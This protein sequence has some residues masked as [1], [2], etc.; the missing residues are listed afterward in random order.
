MTILRSHRSKRESSYDRT[1]GNRDWIELAPGET[2]TLARLS[3]AGCINRLYFIIRCLDHMYLRKLV[4]RAYWDGEETPSVEVPFGD[5]FGNTNGKLC[6][7][8]S[9]AL[10]VNPGGYGANVADGFNCFLPMPFGSSA[11]L[12]IQNQGESPILRC[13]YHVDYEE[14]DSLA[15][16]VGR[17]HAQWRREN[18]TVAESQPPGH[19]AGKNVTG[20]KN[21]VVLDAEGRGNFV[22]FVFGVDNSCGDWWG[23]GDDMIF[24]DGESWPP[25]LHGTGTEEIF[26][27]GACPNVPYAGAYMGIHQ[28]SDRMWA[29]KSGMYRFFINDPIRFQRSIRVTIEHGHN[30][31]LANDYTSVA[32][33]YQQEPHRTFPSLPPVD[34]RLPHMAAEYWELARRERSVSESYFELSKRLPDK[35]RRI[36]GVQY[37]KPVFEAFHREDYPSV[38]DLL[39]RFERGLAEYAKYAQQSGPGEGGNL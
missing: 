37:Q 14:M 5:F 3:G 33:W 23:E 20:E 34:Q 19:W 2:V 26:G 28:I 39:S 32:Y 18:P 21:Y 25:S 11:R 38:A 27:G 15:P 35:E 12:E 10:A 6:Y 22:G 17:L 24:I 4:L 8:D 31:D 7:F 30:N 29:G 13:W 1:G 9:L 36:L 16:E